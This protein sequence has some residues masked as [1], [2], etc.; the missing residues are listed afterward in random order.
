MIVVIQHD[1]SSYENF[2]A[3]QDS[4]G[5]SNLPIIT[6]KEGNLFDSPEKYSLALV[7]RLLYEPRHCR[8]F[9]TSFRSNF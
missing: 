8:D 2:I 7:P 5:M 6:K 1:N 3:L 4:Q 9:Q